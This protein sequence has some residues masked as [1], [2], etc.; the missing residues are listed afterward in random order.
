MNTINPVPYAAH[1]AALR[2][3]R[4]AMLASLLAATPGHLFGQNFPVPGGMNEFS[5]VII[6]QPNTA[7]VIQPAV[8]ADTPYTDALIT[9]DP[10]ASPPPEAFAPDFPET[11]NYEGPIGVTG[12]F[13]GNVTT[14]CSYDPS[15]HNAHRIIDDLVVPGSIGKYPLKMTRY[16]NSR[17]QYYALSAIGLSPGWAH[18]YSW[19]LWGAGTKVISPHGNVYDFF[20]SGSP[21]IGVSEWWEGAHSGGNGTWRLADGG[22]VRFDNYQVKYIDDPYGQRTRIAYINDVHDPKNGQRVK[23][24]E[25][26]GRCLWFI[27]GDQNHGFDQGIE[28]GDWTWLLTRVEAYDADGSPG[29]PAPPTGNLIG[30]VNYSY[31]TRDPIN[32]VIRNRKQKMLIRVDYPDSSADL[33]DSTHAHYEYRQDNVPENQTIQKR[34]PLI[35]RCDDVRYN[36]PMRTIRYEYQNNT[37]HGAIINEKY[38]GVGAV[39]AMSP[40]PT[41]GP[42][43]V[44]AFTETRGDGPTRSFY[45]TH[46]RRCQGTEC[47]PCDDYE[48]NVPPQQM[49]DHYSDFQNK[50]TQ[51]HYDPNWYIDSVTDANGHITG[52]T[53]GSPPPASIGEIRT[54]TLPAGDNNSYPASTIQYNYE[55]ETAPTPGV[56]PIQGHYLK[57]ITDENGKTTTLHRDSHYRITQIDYPQDPNTPASHEYFTYCD[58]VDSQCNNTLG[59]IK[60]HRLKNGAYVHYRYDSR[61]VLIDKWE[62]TSNDSALE[63]DPK[64]HYDYYLGGRWKDRLKTVTMPPNWPNSYQASETYEY[65]LDGNSQPCAGRGLITK[66]TYVSPTSGISHSFSYDQ[67]GN[68]IYEWNELGEQSHYVYDNYNRLLSA[69]KGGE[70]TT[71]TYNPTNGGASPYLHI[72]NNPDTI[73]SPTGILTHNVYDP[74][75]RKTS[76]SV[77]GSTT[78]FGY[79]FVG[80][81][82]CMTDPRGSGQCSTT[83]TTTTHYDS[84]NR[85]DYVNDAQGHRTTFTYDNAT[86]ITRIDRPN[87][88]WEAK[89]YDAVNR[90]IRDTI[91]FTG[92]NP[93]VNLETWFTYWPSGTL[94]TVTDPRGTVGRTYPSGDANFTTAF[95]YNES[96]QRTA[97]SYPPID[98]H[99]DAQGWGYDAAHNLTSHA[100]PNGQIEFFAYDQRNRKYGKAWWGGGS[101]WQWYYFGLDDASRLRDAKNGS[102]TVFDANTVS[103][104]HRE[105]Y[106]TGKLKLDRQTILDQPDGPGLPGKKVNYEYDT[107]FTGA[108]STATRMYVTNADDSA[109]GY[110]YDFRCDDMGRLEKILAHNAALKFQY[111]YDQASNETLRHNEANGVDQSYSPDEL[112]R[113]T[114]TDVQFHN[115]R[116]IESYG[117]W[118]NGLLHTVTRGSNHDEFAY[119]LDGQL[120]QVMYGVPQTEGV[121]SETPPAEDPTKEKTVDDFV[122]MSAPDPDGVLTADRT[123]RYNLDYAGNRTSVNDSVGGITTYSPNNINEYTHQVG[124][125]AIDNGSNHELISYKTNAY[126]YKDQHLT[127]VSSGINGYDLVY[128]ALGRCVKRVLNGVTK[129]YIYDGERPI[130]EYGVNGNV[131]GRNLYGKGIDEILMRT[132]YTFN[133]PATFYY[134]QD[135]E[136]SVTHLTDGSGNLIEQYRYDAFGTPTIYDTA[137]PPHVRGAS[138]VSNRFMFTGRE[139]AATFGFYEYRARAYH[140]GLGRF[141]SEDP[142]GFVRRAGLGKAPDEWSFATHPNEAELNLFRYCGNDPVDYVDPTGEFIDT[143][144]D[145]GF[146]A[147]D[148]YKV[149]TDSGNRGTQLTALGLDVV[150]AALPFA[151]GLGAAYRAGKALE[152]GA[153]VVR[154]THEASKVVQRAMSKAELAE[155][156]RT[157]LLRG[158]REG[159]HYV[160]DSVNSDARRAQQRLALPQKPEVRATLEVPADRLSGPSRVVPNNNMPGRGSE[161]TASGSVPVR[162]ERVDEY[163]Q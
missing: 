1:R 102:G 55:P 108:E 41:F 74:N 124:N 144:I 99:S 38:P 7:M 123:V 20:C 83:F 96:D 95:V 112:N 135:H 128:D 115:G 81:Q 51:L 91:S 125:D 11:T 49:L 52:Y 160:S 145:V 151:T 154:D 120:K 29:T 12:I 152:H 40:P 82:T 111:S 161:R 87:G 105:Y 9:G 72:T 127:N 42:P 8:P 107:Q 66:V 143:L 48:N 60:R 3:A 113:R 148:L 150:G 13:N 78:W 50:L 98:N 19:L 76:T 132:D 46:L 97:M 28:W 118:E 5:N 121:S 116:A 30:W 86:N 70:I 62:P 129:Y 31:E 131:R 4:V 27:Y 136:G 162:V 44:D 109:A 149:A 110:D 103:R 156:Q 106:P 77:A 68:K 126:T 34:Y 17:Q 23:V 39:S 14:G 90:V 146:I 21:P 80:N 119:Y 15:S 58:Q 37:P 94:H 137:T 157:G 73:T 134:Q 89:A 153:E 114:K 142:K 26:G 35:Q 47:A 138:I 85:K 6:E 45:Y 133:P 122:S 84:R 139:Y 140:P 93:A 92:G 141:M 25:P 54:I 69:A 67:Y 159:T 163:R 104:V 88:N 71:Y 117:Y 147:Y 61:G 24:T 130:L 2:K 18:E 10:A 64:T 36:G 101:D 32:P 63:T 65:D 16:Y 75:F 79:D 53:R 57:T 59:Q 158:G 22:R 56:T 33:T 43:T 155:T 100:M